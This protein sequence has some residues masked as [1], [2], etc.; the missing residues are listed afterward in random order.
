MPRNDI[1]Q[2]EDQKKHVSASSFLPVESLFFEDFW[3][4]FPWSMSLF[5]ISTVTPGLGSKHRW[6]AALALSHLDGQHGTAQLLVVGV[7]PA[8]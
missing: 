1:D 6:G 2:T 3:I 8:G 4:A 5:V 7:L